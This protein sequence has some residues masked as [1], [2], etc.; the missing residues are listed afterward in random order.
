M[1]VLL[2]ERNVC[3]MMYNNGVNKHD[4]NFSNY[5][6]NISFHEVLNT[7]EMFTLDVLNPVTSAA[8]IRGCN[9]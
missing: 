7:N 8:K 9:T 1:F 2:R 5:V 6:L 4:N 3:Y